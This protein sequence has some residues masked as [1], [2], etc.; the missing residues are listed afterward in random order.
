MHL[1]YTVKDSIFVSSEK[2]GK[3]L[4]AYFIEPESTKRPIQLHFE[5]VPKGFTN[6]VCFALFVLT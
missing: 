1:Y 3:Y 2:W 6:K 5:L 4:D